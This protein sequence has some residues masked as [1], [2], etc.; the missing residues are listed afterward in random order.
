MQKQEI[1]P[2]TQT[3]INPPSHHL[4]TSAKKKK[5]LTSCCYEREIGIEKK[6]PCLFFVQVETQRDSVVRDSW[7][8]SY[9]CSDCVAI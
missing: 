7:R 4:A 5:N 1:L 2:H 6:H 3:A 9:R 8:L